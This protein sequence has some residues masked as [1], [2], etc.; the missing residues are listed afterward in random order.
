[1]T[2]QQAE[3]LVLAFL[4]AL[5]A[6][7]IAGDVALYAA[8][9]PDATISRVVRRWIE[10]YPSVLLGAVFAL[11]VFVGHCYLPD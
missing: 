7:L 9:G 2:H 11:G 5:L 3:L 10:R 1:M 6:V 4:A 8:H